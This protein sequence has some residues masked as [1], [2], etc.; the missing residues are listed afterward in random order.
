M[1]A[2]HALL[3]PGRIPRDV[4]VR[5]QGAELQIDALS[6]G[7]GGDEV[8]RAAGAA[9]ALDLPFALRPVHPAM[10]LRHAAGMA[11]A[12]QTADQ[13][14]HGVAVL[15]EDEP[16]FVGVARVFEHFAQLLELGFLAGIE[17]G[18]GAGV[19]VLERFDFL[20]QLLDGDGHDR[21]EHR[22]LVIFA[23]F[24]GTVVAGIFVSAM[25]VEIIACVALVQ[26]VLTFP[27]IAWGH[28]PGPQIFGDLTQLADAP[29]ERTRERP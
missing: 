26:V 18:A 4:V 28:A 25:V 19:Q 16:L 10:Y 1:N 8:A 7:V 11:E 21:A 22:H 9:E 2:A 6:R 13:V 27:Q 20:F 24:A 14:V 3:Q 23:R 17:N 5:H 15:G 12:F 29:L